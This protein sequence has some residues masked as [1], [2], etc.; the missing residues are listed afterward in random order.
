MVG[1]KINIAAKN[2]DGVM[3]T[4]FSTKIQLKLRLAAL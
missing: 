2:Q 4:I 1:E 3:W